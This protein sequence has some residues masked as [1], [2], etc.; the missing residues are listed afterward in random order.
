MRIIFK[1]I[2]LVGALLLASC[3]GEGTDPEPRPVVLSKLSVS[4]S[5]VTEND[6]SSTT[7]DFEVRLSTAADDA[8]SV[9]YATSDVT[10][11]AGADYEAASDR[12][13]FPAGTISQ[14]ISITVYADD[15]D[16]ADEQ[17]LLTLSDPDNATISVG[18]AI[19]TIK[20]FKVIVDDSGDGY[21]TPLEYD[22]YTLLWHDEFTDEGLDPNTYTHERGD[23]GWG[24]EELQNYTASPDNSFLREGKLHIVARE[25]G[26]GNYTSA[27]IITK[28]KFSFNFGRVDIRAKVPTAQ[29]IWPAT[30][31]LGSNFSEVGWPACGEIDIM[32]LVGFEPGTIH[33][34]A[35]W[36]Q[37]GWN[38]SIHEGRAK[39][40]PAGEKYSDE[41]HV[42]SIEWQRDRIDWLMD[43]EPYFTLTKNFVAPE[44][45]RFNQ[46][47][48]LILNVAVGGKWPGYPDATTVFPQ[49]MVI[50]YIRVFQ[51]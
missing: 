17:F 6:N 11:R 41:F 16:E 4:N 51:K 23:H 27:R 8:V 40:L 5:T 39:S 24:N 10:A 7:L 32:E 20:N 30:W 14:T 31:M 46:D 37:Q 50:D 26:I 19:G 29:G 35:H 36:G 45:Y 33:G 42:F 38:Y 47:F 13:V 44:T 18:D 48:F 22:D 25:E 43:D 34:T 1:S 3:G 49:E 15:E 9:A 12:L 21:I 2:I 28:D